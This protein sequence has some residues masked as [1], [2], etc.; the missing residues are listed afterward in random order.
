MS[1]GR[2][3]PRVYATTWSRKKAPPCPT[4]STDT[5]TAKFTLGPNAAVFTEDGRRVEPGSGETGLLA[6]TGPIPLGYYGDPKNIVRA[7]KI[8]RSPNGKSDY[9]WAMKTARDA[10]GI[11]D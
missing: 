7:E 4:A 6:V 10:L 5:E 1:V 3:G 9:K 2:S 8:F 11:E